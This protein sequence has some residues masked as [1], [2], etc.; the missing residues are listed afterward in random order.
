V[1]LQYFGAN[2]VRINSRKASI[3]IDDNL[4]K[5]GLKS[6]TKAD[7][8]SL[9]T[10]KQVPKNSGRFI[11]DIPGEY[12]ISGIIIRGITARAH[13]D[14]EGQT[15][16]VIYTLT[17]GELRIAVVG[18]IFPELSEDQLDQIG[19]VDIAII[20]VGNS[21]YTLDGA[22]AL[23]LIKAIEPRV[24]VPTHYGD[25]RIKYEVPQQELAEALKALGMEPKET[26]AKYKPKAADLTD[27]THLIVLERQ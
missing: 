2:C 27:T 16:A 13:M 1:E 17:D 18:H 3:I 25:K 20:P 22:G 7:D 15:N 9:R 23:K 12:E 6:I 14:P 26:V 24:V 19:L 4:A 21:G 10:S 11:V 8:I 5:L